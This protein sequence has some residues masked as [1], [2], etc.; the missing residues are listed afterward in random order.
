MLQQIELKSFKCFDVLKLPLAE[1]TLLSGSNASGK[2]SLLQAL[3]LLHQTIQENEWGTRLV[4]NGET[5]KLGTVQD[6]VNKVYGR[7]GFELMLKNEEDTYRWRFQGE[8]HEMSMAIEYMQ[9]SSD[10]SNIQTALHFLLPYLSNRATP[11]ICIKLESLT[12]ITAERIGPRD[13]YHLEDRSKIKT[14]GPKGEHAVSRLFSLADKKVY[15]GLCIDTAPKILLRQVEAWM[16]RFFPGCGIEVAQ[17]A[18]MNAVTLGIR[19]SDET[20][21]HRPINVGFGLTQVL[22]ILVAVLSAE[23]DSLVLI[24]NP[25]VHLHPA[26]QA[27]MGSFLALAASTGPQIIIETHSDHV[28]NGIRRIVRQ[29]IIKPQQVALHFFRPLTKGLDQVVSPQVDQSGNLDTWPEGFFDQFDKD[30]NYFA[31]WG[32]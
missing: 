24:E 19:T 28:L 6:V 17:I 25:E 12:Y 11:E 15:D 8:R 31:G 23:P 10:E 7:N 20:D 18:R 5:L 29:E 14:V 2:S 21:Y 32:E 13:F 30:M 27:L 16:Q 4:L 26:G 22:P 3:V 1:L 9:N